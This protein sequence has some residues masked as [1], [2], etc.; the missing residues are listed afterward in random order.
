MVKKIMDEL[1]HILRINAIEPEVAAHRAHLL[2]DDGEGCLT[3]LRSLSRNGS[4]IRNDDASVCLFEVNIAVP[5][6]EQQASS[7]LICQQSGIHTP[8]VAFEVKVSLLLAPEAIATSPIA[9]GVSGQRSIA[10][11]LHAVDVLVE[12]EGDAE[13][14]ENGIRGVGGQ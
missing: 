6:E 10:Y 13:F 8:T 5:T 2:G 14:R 11:P 3:E 1:R 4:I 12:Q 7:V 9:T